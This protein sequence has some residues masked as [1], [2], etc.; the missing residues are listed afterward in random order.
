MLNII[1]VKEIIIKILSLF[2]H[3]LAWT[4]RLKRAGFLEF[5]GLKKI[6]LTF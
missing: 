3:A 6:L 4:K 5:T 1:D 2:M